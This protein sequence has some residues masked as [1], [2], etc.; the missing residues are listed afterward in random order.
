MTIGS[1]YQ[2]Y[3]PQER[4]LGVW[5]NREG[6]AFLDRERADTEIWKRSEPADLY[7]VYI[8]TKACKLWVK[9]NGVLRYSGNC[10]AGA[11]IV[12][13][14][15]ERVY[16][17][18]HGPIRSLQ[19]SFTDAFLKEHLTDLSV[20][21]DGVELRELPHSTDVALMNLVRAH[22]AGLE[23]GLSGSQ[24][25]FDV[26]RQA[27]LNRIA[28]LHATRPIARK[29]FADMLSPAQTR[30]V[31]DYIEAN[32]ECDLRL[33]EL[34]AVAR[35][36]RAHFARAFRNMTGMGAHAYVM[37]RRLARALQL[38]K[39]HTASIADIAQACGFA[40][41]AHLTRNFKAFYG[42]P[43]SKLR[44]AQAS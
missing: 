21:P 2:T 24:L 14:P 4:I 11:V 23:N 9:F 44:S 41:H 22:Q 15:D 6:L 38:V 17:S 1:R 37:Q 5:E 10:P 26:V 19:A 27:I 31:V 20:R 13:R 43:P 40:D 33:K 12:A 34:A 7:H 3:V 16:A 28:V 18:G 39:R 32:L 25:Y 42:V 29:A 30:R 8:Q 36:S 35:V